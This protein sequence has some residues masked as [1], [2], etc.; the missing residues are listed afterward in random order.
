MSICGTIPRLITRMVRIL[1]SLGAATWL[2]FV[3]LRAEAVHVGSR[4]ELMVDDYLVR[5]MD[6]GMQRRLHHPVEREVV[7]VL[8]APWEGSSCGVFT[9]FQ[10]RDLYRMYYR[11]WQFDIVEEKLEQPHRMVVCYAESRDGIEWRKPELGLVDFEGSKRNNIIWDGIGSHNFTP[12]KDANPDCPETECYKAIG[13][14]KSEGGLFAFASSDGIH[15]TLV[16]EKPIITK[17]Y[18]DSQNLAFWDSERSEYRA[19]Y[20]DLQNYPHGRD[21]LTA[22]SRDFVN[23]QEFP[24]LEYDP[25]R[26]TE[27]YTN[28]ILPYY[29]APHILLGFPMRYIERGES[30]TGLNKR[31]SR[32][33]DRYGKAQTDTGFMTSR[34]ARRFKVWGEAFV[35]PGPQ[36][37]DFSRWAYADS[38]Q[39]WGMVET[40]SAVE[41]TPP[42][43]SFY[44]LEDYWT[45]KSVRMR[46]VTLRIDGFVSIHAPLSG[47]EFVTRPLTFDGN[48]LRVNFSTSAAGSIRVEI[49]DEDGE[50]IPGFALA[51][52]PEIFGDSLERIVSWGQAE[53]GSLAGR[54]IRLRF[55]LK[56]ADL[57]AFGFK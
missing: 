6:A 48:P 9:V 56:D 57:F 15:W 47:G 31:L 42:E 37:E 16:Q 29:R 25:E 40:G 1:A 21:I 30:M 54:P 26:Y 43:L 52:C 4:W 12:F 17:G 32:V 7:L 23:W 38:I 53:V 18:F 27:L 51:D 36:R 24:F 5:R 13:G 14:I 46:R 20:R 33:R 2:G 45:G 41:G 44:I 19:Y 39:A 11:G 50:P 8:D 34:D 35:R 28:Q 22:T 10:D 55:M 49:Q 3:P